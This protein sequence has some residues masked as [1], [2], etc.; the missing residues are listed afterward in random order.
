MVQIA[1]ARGV[2]VITGE[3][4]SEALRGVDVVIDVSNPTPDPAAAARNVVGACIARGVQ[5]VVLLTIACLE[6]A[7]FDGYP[8]FAAKRAAKKIVLDSQVPATIVTSTQFHEFAT[9]PAAVICNDD[10]VIVQDWLIQP[11]AADT[12]AD[13]LVEAALAQTRAPRTI[14][15]PHAIRLPRLTA[16]YLAAQGDK[17]RVRAVKPVPAALAA[18]VLLAPSHAAVVGPDVDTWLQTLMLPRTDGN[19]DQPEKPRSRGFLRV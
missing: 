5:R 1:R 13:V 17:R 19:S 2:D 11:V 9:N 18:G 7:A 3:G 15:G 14:T 4:L 10:E 6:Q 16:K 12:V 8:T